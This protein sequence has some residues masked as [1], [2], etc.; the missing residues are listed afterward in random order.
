MAITL[1]AL[2]F[3]LFCLFCPQHIFKQHFQKFQHFRA[4]LQ[5]RW[6]YFFYCLKGDLHSRPRFIILLA[7]FCKLIK[8]PAYL[9]GIQII[10]QVI[11]Q[12]FS[13]PLTLFQVLSQHWLGIALVIPTALFDILQHLTNK[14]SANHTIIG[15]KQS[16]YGDVVPPDGWQSIVFLPKANDEIAT[17][18][19]KEK[20]IIVNKAVNDWLLNGNDVA[21]KYD[22]HYSQR[23]KDK[24]WDDEQWIGLY[25]PFLKSNYLLSLYSG[26][27]FYNESKF[28]ISQ[29]LYPDMESVKIHKT[30]YYDF[31][32]TN[33]I[34]GRVLYERINTRHSIETNDIMPFDEQRQL[35]KL[36]D[37]TAANEVGVTTLFLTQG[38]IILWRQNLYT[39]SSENKIAPSGSG[40]MDWDDCVPYLP[41]DSSAGDSNG[42]RKAIVYGMQRELWEECN[43]SRKITEHDFMEKVETVIIGYFRWLQKA[44][45]P[46]FI[47]VTRVRDGVDLDRDFHLRIESM[48]P[49]STEIEDEE[50]LTVKSIGQFL[51]R[52]PLK[53]VASQRFQIGDCSVPYA[54]AALRLREL[55][56]DYCRTCSKKV[57]NCH[58]HCAVK[59]EDAVFYGRTVLRVSHP[60]A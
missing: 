3:V 13:V 41:T 25:K 56:D 39:Q 31:Y 58:E 60:K 10:G 54:A 11:G 57:E 45:T 48:Q 49:E 20:P 7:A 19:W 6:D 51:D 15:I 29:E 18:D 34:P 8:F 33:T 44:G 32:L 4:K 14:N 46:E 47:G 43:G 50:N 24:L 38:K 22:R 23:I 9:A 37:Y 2:S 28:G 55:C 12:A 36:G 17:T 26:K 27:Q 1:V 53:A 35:L 52:F 40:S 30:C 59:L 16:A 42:F 21:L 5:N